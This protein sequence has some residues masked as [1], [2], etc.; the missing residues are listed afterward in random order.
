M[1]NLKVKGTDVESYNQ[2]FQELA[3]MCARMFP[4]ESDKIE[5]YVGGLPDMIYGSVKASKP[6]TMQDAIKFAIELMDKKIITFVEHQ[7]ELSKPA[8]TFEKAECGVM[9]NLEFNDSFAGA[10]AQVSGFLMFR[11]VKKLKLL[12]KPLQKLLYEK[13]NLYANVVHCRD[14]LDSV[15]TLL[16]I[17]P[18]NTSLRA[19]E[20]ACVVA[21][22]EAALLEERM[23]K[24]RAKITWLKEG[25]SNSTYF[26]KAVKSRVS[27]SRIDAMTNMEGV[28]CENEQVPVA[29]VTHYEAFLGLVGET[30]GFVDDNL[31]K[32]RLHDQIA[33]NM[34]REVTTQEVKQAMFSM[35]DDKSPGPDGYTVAFF[36]EAW[37]I[38]ATDVTDASG[39]SCGKRHNRVTALQLDSNGLEGSLSPHVGNLTFH[40]QLD[41]SNN[42]FQGT[43]SHEIGRLSRLR[44]LYLH[45]NKISGFI[46]TNLFVV[47]TLKTFGSVKMS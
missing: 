31:F 12:K 40:R 21:F 30:I 4:K 14:E 36:K 42:S 8:A 13:G 18:Y 5:K 39:I 17:D 25:D 32:T 43:I 22:N 26:H 20:A 2:R 1:W 24:Q 16:D 37:E 3:L 45:R 10:H 6:R 46:P 11:V 35:G 9:S 15:Q 47:L 7:A 38:V 23:L 28:L 41:I 44:L 27:R 33:L 34:I 19:K 29:F